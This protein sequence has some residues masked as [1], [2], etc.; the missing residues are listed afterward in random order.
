MEHQFPIA[1][2]ETYYYGVPV[3]TPSRECSMLG[4]LC[5]QENDCARDQLTQ[6]TGLC[7]DRE[8]GVECC[9]QGT[10]HFIKSTIQNK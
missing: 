6:K 3:Y 7:Q 9:Y 4:G 2:T 10:L 1:Q 5:V 8:N